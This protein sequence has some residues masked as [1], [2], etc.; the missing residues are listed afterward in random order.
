MNGLL[1]DDIVS[2]LEWWCA[3]VTA[4]LSF[5][6]SFFSFSS[7]LVLLVLLLL[8]RV[9]FISTRSFLMKDERKKEVYLFSFLRSSRQDRRRS[10]I[11]LSQDYQCSATVFIWSSV[12]FSSSNNV[13]WKMWTSQI[14]DSLTIGQQMSI[15]WNR[16]YSFQDAQ[17]HPLPIG[18]RFLSS[19]STKSKVYYSNLG[20][21]LDC[22]AEGNPKPVVRWFR[23]NQ[24]SETSRPILIQTSDLM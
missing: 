6:F 13:S 18:P 1:F 12:I 15:D 22:L 16:F 8:F 2:S 7:L 17:S 11:S 21:R 24:P 3:S 19:I 9:S 20:V 4:C 23:L 10:Q 14:D 5:T